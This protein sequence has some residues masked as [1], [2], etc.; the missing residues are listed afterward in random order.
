MPPAF[1]NNLLSTGELKYYKGMVYSFD[2]PACDL[3]WLLHLEKNGPV[4]SDR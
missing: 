3:I 4:L 1:F 2:R